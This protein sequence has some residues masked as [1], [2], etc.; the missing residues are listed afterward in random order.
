MPL[1][2]LWPA[3]PAFSSGPWTP[4]LCLPDLPRVVPKCCLTLG[5]HLSPAWPGRP[6]GDGCSQHHP[7]MLLFWYGMSLQRPVFPFPGFGEVG[8]PIC[9]GLQMAAKSWLPLLQL[10]FGSGRPRCGLARGGLLYRGGV[11]LAA[12]AQMETGCCSL[13]WGNH[14]FTPYHSQNVA[15]RERGTLEVPSQPPLWLICLRQQYRHQMERKDLGERLTPWSG[16]PV[17]SV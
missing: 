12:G 7:W 5:T 4:P 15:G 13:Y 3:R 16:T 9:S 6:V 1:S 14:S 10:S 11:R 17:G 8:L 2:W